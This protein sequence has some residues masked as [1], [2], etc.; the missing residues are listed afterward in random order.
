MRFAMRYLKMS[1]LDEGLSSLELSCHGAPLAR[2]SVLSRRNE[3]EKED[4]KRL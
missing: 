4:L 3:N 1:D 2:V